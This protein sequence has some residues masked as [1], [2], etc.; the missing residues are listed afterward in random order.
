MDRLPKTMDLATI[1]Y[2]IKYLAT[3]ETIIL[4]KM[5]L[6]KICFVRNTNFVGI[7]C[8]SNNT[9]IQWQYSLFGIGF[10]DI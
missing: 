1:V 8:D 3:I 4:A 6:T 9:I 5:H 7:K 10:T 2:K